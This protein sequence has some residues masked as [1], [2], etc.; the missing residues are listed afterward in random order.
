MKII[1]QFPTFLGEVRQ[2]ARRITWPSRKEVLLT[3]LF[4]FLFTVIASVFFFIVDSG[5]F[6]FIHAIIG[7]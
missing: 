2:E 5:L 6:K 4:V 7:G 3:S 1:K